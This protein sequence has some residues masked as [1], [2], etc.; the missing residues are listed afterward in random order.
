MPYY[1]EKPIYLQFPHPIGTL[2]GPGDVNLGVVDIDVVVH[3]VPPTRHPQWRVTVQLWRYRVVEVWQRR[4]EVSCRLEDEIRAF[5]PVVPKCHQNSGAKKVEPAALNN[6]ASMS[7][8]AIASEDSRNFIS[9]CHDY[10]PFIPKRG[11]SDYLYHPPT[12]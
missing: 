9:N 10:C 1:T 2:V 3:G 5:I 8:N 7:I 4:G 12:H 11:V 6:F